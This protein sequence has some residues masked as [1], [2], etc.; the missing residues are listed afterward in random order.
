MSGWCFCGRPAVDPPPSLGVPPEPLCAEHEREAGAIEARIRIRSVRRA[1]A[2][3][4]AVTVVAPM[5]W[6][7]AADPC[8]VPEDAD[9]VTVIEE[10][11]GAPGEEG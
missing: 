8:E 9:A 7:P 2:L 1:R 4:E 5:P 6:V 10:R 11:P 3:C